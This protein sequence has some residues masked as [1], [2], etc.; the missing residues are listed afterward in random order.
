MKK[1]ISN[2]KDIETLIQLFYE[3]VMLD[4]VIGFIFTEVVSIHWEH[5]I[6]LIV[7]FWESILLDN[8]VYKKNAMEMHYDLNKK[9]P[10]E[11]IHFDRW[12]FLFNDVIDELHEGKIATMAKTRAQSIAAVM[13]FK[14]EEAHQKNNN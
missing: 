3:K 8:P 5:H 7:D 1:D 4:P 6:P 12:L 11:K 2:R 13:Q 14:M 9:M 10:L